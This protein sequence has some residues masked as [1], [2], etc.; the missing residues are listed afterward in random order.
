MYYFALEI[1][2]RSRGQY[3]PQQLKR[4]AQMSGTFGKEIDNILSDSGIG[5]F[6]QRKGHGRATKYIKKMW[7]NLSMSSLRML[8]LVIYLDVITS[9]LT[10][11]L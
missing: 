3:T 9:A 5:H 4:C 8:C 1:L 2:L 10:T 6:A 11:S 7:P